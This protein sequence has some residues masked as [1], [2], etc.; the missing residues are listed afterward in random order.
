MTPHPLFRSYIAA[1]RAYKAQRKM[2]PATIPSEA[3]LV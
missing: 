3:E 1:A 2:A